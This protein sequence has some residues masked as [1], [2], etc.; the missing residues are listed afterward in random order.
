MA[1]KYDDIIDL[2]HPTSLKHPRMSMLDRGAQFAPFSALVGYEEA[3]AES[4]RLTQQQTYLSEE[5]KED[6][7]R[8]LRTI[9]EHL[10]EFPPVKI[11]VFCPDLR[12]DGGSYEEFTAT[13]QRIDPLTKT[14]L[15][16]DG[17]LVDME[18][19]CSLDLCGMD[20]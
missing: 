11:R 4:S 3:I 15:L 2:P 7:N 5:A 12:K 10:Q 1:G 18:K 13:V 16:T 6:L 20:N 17:Q 14:V 9:H 19:I 8:K